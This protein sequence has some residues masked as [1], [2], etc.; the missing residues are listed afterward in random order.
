VKNLTKTRKDAHL[1]NQQNQQSEH[2]GPQPGPS[3]QPIQ[4]PAIQPTQTTTT[5]SQTPKPLIPIKTKVMSTVP[6]GTGTASF[7]VPRSWDG[8]APK[9]TTDD[10]EDLKDFIDQVNEILSLARITDDD[11]KKKLLT[12]YLPNK[13]KTM[14]R[15][16]ETYVKG[17]YEDFLKEVYDSYP[18]L[19]QEVEGTLR[20][21]ERLCAKYKGIPLHDE[22]KLKRFGMEFTSL[23]KK[24]T[25][26]P[27][28]ILNKEACQRYLDTLDLSFANTL[29]SSISAHNMLKK[30]LK[31]VKGTSTT[32]AASAMGGSS[33]TGVKTVVDH[34]KEDPILLKELVEMAEQLAATGVAGISWGEN[35]PPLAKRPSSVFSVVKVDKN[36]ERFEEFS[37]ELASLKD[38]FDVIRK[39]SQATKTE[40]M[41]S[42]AELLRAFQN[43]LRGPPPHMDNGR[44]ENQNIELRGVNANSFDRFRR[45]DR[46]ENGRSRDICYYCDQGDHFSRDC[47][48]KMAHIAKGWLG[49]EEGIPKLVDGSAIP[50]GRGSAAQRVE[51]YW[52]KKP[53][54]QNMYSSMDN[55][56]GGEGEEVESLRDE[57]RTHRARLNQLEGVHSRPTYQ[58][59]VQPT[60]M[61]QA[62]APVQ[63]A[64]V[65]TT[66]AAP[67]FDD[68]AKAMYKSFMNGEWSQNQFV[69]TR[70]GKD[71]G[72]SAQDF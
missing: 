62:A 37:G 45:S 71:S 40:L 29:R 15:D 63:N 44:S 57:L 9:F 2:L 55:F 17:T 30:E 54:S 5:T 56:Y 43:Q 14:W 61:A 11:E 6:T 69:T 34:R 7:K 52:Q 53:R 8:N 66:Q 21:L 13:K 20:E 1:E 59:P 18:E 12:S 3:T 28:I 31:K 64:N 48:V 24:L 26:E 42:N 58:P 32:A 38:S 22:G 23:I 68:F 46:G 65:A 25:M 19:R 60:Y 67:S 33:T 41:N 27:A 16:L 36:N 10:A 72:A 35:E 47:P 49:V 50:R 4:Q 51:E 70:G 39:E